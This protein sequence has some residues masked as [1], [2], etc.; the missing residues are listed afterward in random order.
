MFGSAW[1]RCQAPMTPIF[2]DSFF[3]QLTNGALFKRKWF[4]RPKTN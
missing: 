4:D 1:G 3:G 2:T